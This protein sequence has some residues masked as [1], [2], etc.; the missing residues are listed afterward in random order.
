MN[1]YNV[2]MI[3][4]EFKRGLGNINTDFYSL[5]K[6]NNGVGIQFFF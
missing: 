5:Y 3:H 2:G 6:D 4:N 1:L